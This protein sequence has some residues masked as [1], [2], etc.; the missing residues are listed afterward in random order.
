MERYTMF[1]NW[2]IQNCENDYTTQSDLQ[3]QCNT[4]QLPKA[5]FTELEQKLLQ[6]AWN[7][8]DSKLTEAILRKKKKAGGITLPDLSLYYKDT[9]TKIV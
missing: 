6:L 9:L 2:K 3:I 1:L 8:K 4:Y 5:F 7:T